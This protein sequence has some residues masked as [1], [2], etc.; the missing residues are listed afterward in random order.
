MAQA[1][2]PLAQAG[3]ELGMGHFLKALDGRPRI[4]QDEHSFLEQMQ[5]QRVMD[6]E[7]ESLAFVRARKAVHKRSGGPNVRRK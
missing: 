2:Q 6:D 4:S 3:Q 1:L 7:P 5:M